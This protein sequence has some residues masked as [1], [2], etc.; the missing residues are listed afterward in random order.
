MIG[1]FIDGLLLR[2]H[3]NKVIIAT[4]VHAV[5]PNLWNCFE[6]AFFHGKRRTGRRDIVN[7]VSGIKFIEQRNCPCTVWASRPRYDTCAYASPVLATIFMLLQTQPCMVS[8]LT[9]QPNWCVCIFNT[10]RASLV[11]ARRGAFFFENPTGS[12]LIDFMQ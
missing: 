10:R 2:L 7:C 5:N 8:I 6:V 4:N 9:N 1:A 12:K 3:S 11:S